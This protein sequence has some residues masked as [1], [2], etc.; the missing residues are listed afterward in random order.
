MNSSLRPRVTL[1]PCSFLLVVFLSPMEAV[2]LDSAAPA[3]PRSVQKHLHILWSH[4]PPE[5]KPCPPFL[6]LSS[7]MGK[8]ADEI[9]LPSCVNHSPSC[10]C[11]LHRKGR[12]CYIQLWLQ[13]PCPP[14]LPMSVRWLG[15]SAG[16]LK[17]PSLISKTLG[18]RGAGTS[19]SDIV[20]MA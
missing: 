18:G 16:P 2:R 6:S 19:V 7:S 5:P 1:F 12:R 8:G 11:L 10:S 9:L 17:F 14:L 4:R 3:H 13:I 15:A 20:N